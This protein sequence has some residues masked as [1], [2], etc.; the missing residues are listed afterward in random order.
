MSQLFMGALGPPEGSNSTI[1]GNGVT[2]H[3]T[4][5]VDGST[6]FEVEDKGRTLYFKNLLSTVGLEG[7]TMPPVIYE[8]EESTINNANVR[9]NTSSATG[10]LY[11][12]ARLG[13]ATT[14]VEWD[15]S[16][17]SAGSYLI[18]L[19][20]ALDSEPRPLDVSC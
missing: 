7:W 15:V 18:S 20:Y 6:V 1:L 16:V 3:V 13:N 12:E 4:G 10:R 14:Y 8:A 5:A 17:P 19:R 9:N 2:V 11:V